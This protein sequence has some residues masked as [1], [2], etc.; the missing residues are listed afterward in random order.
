MIGWLNAGLPALPD[1][2]ADSPQACHHVPQ[3]GVPRP[4]R[5]SRL[6]LYHQSSWLYVLQYVRDWARAAMA[7]LRRL[8][9]RLQCSQWAATGRG[10]RFAPDP[11][12]HWSVGSA[13]QSERMSIWSPLRTQDSASHWRRV[14]SHPSASVPPHVT[15]GYTGSYWSRAV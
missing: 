11:D 4:T 3:G 8:R 5:A 15:C 7:R 1:D 10:T 14:H 6:R 2:I 9:R 13:A 12:P